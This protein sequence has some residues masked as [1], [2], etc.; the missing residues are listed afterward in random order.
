M[1]NYNQKNGYSVSSIIGIVFLILKLTHV[2]SWS[3]W[4]VLLPFYAPALLVIIVFMIAI[5]FGIMKS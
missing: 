4:F 3:W 5:I 1:K 2:I